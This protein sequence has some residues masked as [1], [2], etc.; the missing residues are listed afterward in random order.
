[1]PPISLRTALERLVDVREG[2]VRGVGWSFAFFLALLTA[3]SILKPV[4]DEMAVA[5]DL[6]HL[7]WLFTATFVGTLA[8]VPAY[9]WVAA[10]VPRRRLVAWVY[11]FC[12]ATLLGFFLLIRAELAPAAVARV[13]FV[14]VSV[15]NLFVTSLFW[16]F[17]AD[18]FASGQGKRLFGF[19]AAGGTAGAIAGPLLAA[20]LAPLVGP[21]TLLVLS[22]L[23][24]E[25]AARCAGRVGG[26]A[27]GAGGGVR[28]EG[29]VGGRAFAGFTLVFRSPYLLA[30][31]G[32]TLLYA[33]TSTLLYAQY[34]ALVER[35]LADPARR[36]ALFGYV[37][38]GSQ[39]LTLLV[40][41]LASGRILSRL[42]LGFGLSLQPLLS[43]LGFGALALVPFLGP[44]VALWGLRRAAHH[45]VERPARE[46]LFTG[47][48]REARY[49]AKSFIDT[50]VYRGGDA[51]SGWLNAGLV[52]AG[53]GTGGV[54]LIAVP[55]AAGGVAL[56][57]FLARRH[58]RA[59]GEDAR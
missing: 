14:W 27:G 12:A 22:A 28:D 19:I 10:R 45:A 21:A 3:Y 1:M 58:R 38:A 37:D 48:D 4:R 36:V 46:V 59:V 51:A 15:F 13:F 11:R 40:Q 6:R 39:A 35:A 26:W 17:M 49:K 31:A 32:A 57:W 7:Q 43:A 9:S 8:A 24:F 34:L 42:G 29:P 5:G 2:E 52:A 33:I 20:T 55:F 30:I 23:L 18:V 53:L 25:G 41:L 16:A 50:V 44:A 54:A 47:V 56:A